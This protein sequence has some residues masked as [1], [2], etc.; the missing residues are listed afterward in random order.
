MWEEM[1][2]AT[3]TEIIMTEDD[4]LYASM[5]RPMAD[6]RPLH[7]PGSGIACQHILFNVSSWQVVY[8]GHFDR[9]VAK[10]VMLADETQRCR[11]ALAV[12]T[13]F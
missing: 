4:S 1:V 11:D 5:D 12:S 6:S 8:W 7:L 2:N 13:V 9:I 10:L 3:I